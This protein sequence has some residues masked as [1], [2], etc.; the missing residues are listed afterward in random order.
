[1]TE[2]DAKMMLEPCPFCGERE[3]RT[4]T[5]DK[6]GQTYWHVRCDECWATSHGCYDLSE[7]DAIKNWNT[8]TAAAPVAGRAEQ[9]KQDHRVYFGCECCEEHAPENGV[10]CR[11]DIGVM[12]DGAWLCDGCYSDCDKSAYGMIASDVDD[13]EFPRFEDLPRPTPY[14]AEPAAPSLPTQP[15]REEVREALE[16][17]RPEIERQFHK[18]G[19]DEHAAIYFEK[20][21]AK[22]D[23]ALAQSPKAQTTDTLTAKQFWSALKEHCAATPDKSKVKALVMVRFEDVVAA[24][25]SPGDGKVPECDHIPKKAALDDEIGC[26]R[27]GQWLGKAN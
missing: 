3:A 14:L 19:A 22:I 20:L 5:Y 6:Y 10:N 4:E 11:E 23:A 15:A 18:C 2:R 26:I 12:P 17:A 7:S 25:A 27:C 16:A 21:L 9:Q 24:L 8:R 1:M 13:F